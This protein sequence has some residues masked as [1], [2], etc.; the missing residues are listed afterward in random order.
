MLKC[1]SIEFFVMISPRPAGFFYVC[2]KKPA[3]YACH[4]F[5]GF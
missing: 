5:V 2:N 3:P 4:T 1:F